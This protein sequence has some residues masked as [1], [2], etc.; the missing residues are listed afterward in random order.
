MTTRVYNVA[1][2]GDPE[3]ALDAFLVNVLRPL[4]RGAIVTTFVRH[5]E[6]CPCVEASEPM[7][8]CTCEIVEVEVSR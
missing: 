5:D 7:R 8:S 1:T 2:A 6:G 3:R 4:R